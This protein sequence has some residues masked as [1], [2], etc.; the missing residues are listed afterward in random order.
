[1]KRPD[2]AWC[3]GEVIKP[4]PNKRGEVFCT[5]YHRTASNAALKR[6]LN[7]PVEQIHGVTEIAQRIERFPNS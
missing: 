1:M 2:C 6:L 5:R 3:G 4:Y 7:K